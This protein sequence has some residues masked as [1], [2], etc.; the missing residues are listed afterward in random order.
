MGVTASRRGILDGTTLKSLSKVV[1]NILLPSLTVTTVINALQ[2]G[3]IASLSLLPVY[4]MLQT[5]V[6]FLIGAKA[7]R[8]NCSSVCF[9]SYFTPIRLFL[10]TFSALALL[11]LGCSRRLLLHIFVA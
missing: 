6:G 7:V 4:A 10:P 1:Y 8:E 3:S 2:K 11:W 9:S 5:L